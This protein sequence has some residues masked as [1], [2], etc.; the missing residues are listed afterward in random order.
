MTTYTVDTYAW[1]AYFEG[2]KKFKAEIEQSL[3]QTPAIVLAELAKAMIRKG[4]NEKKSGEILK[5]VCETSI[6]LEL[7]KKQAIKGGETSAKEKLPLVDGIIYSYVT[8]DAQLLTGDKHFENK[9]L[10]KYI[11]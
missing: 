3:L 11:K 10:A 6:I 5:Y 2:N 4:F 8:E 1:I 7:D 9:A